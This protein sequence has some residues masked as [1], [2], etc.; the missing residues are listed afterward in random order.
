MTSRYPSCRYCKRIPGV[1]ETLIKAPATPFDQV[2]S[3][4]PGVVVVPT[5]GMILPGY[6]LVVSAKHALSFAE[7]DSAALKATQ[8]FVDSITSE[9]SKTFGDYL[10]FEHG[11]NASE[12]SSH[13]ACIAHAH[14][15][16]IPAGTRLKSAVLSA[17]RWTSIEGLEA[18]PDGDL[19]SY[20]LCGVNGAYYVSESSTPGSQWIRRRV[21]EWLGLSVSW[22][23]TSYPGSEE[24]QET[25]R[26]LSLRS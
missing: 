25:F 19:G 22:D 8:L 16:L 13:G 17:L 23:W 5:V 24:L 2:L 21:V 11:P 3:I 26:A 7:L 10:V 6:F 20:A 4:G 14:L 9:L 1:G 18:L 12:A 15:H